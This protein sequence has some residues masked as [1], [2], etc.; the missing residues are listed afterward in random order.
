[1]AVNVYQQR[2]KD[3]M[4]KETVYVF[5]DDSLDEALALMVENRV[6]AL[7][8]VDGHQR[9]IG[10]IS[11]TDL[12]NLTREFGD[13][14]NALAHV[15]GLAHTLLTE[16]LS[17]SG[18]LNRRV[19]ELMTETVVSIGPDDTLIHAATEMVRSRVHRLAV[20]DR[21]RRLRGI[22]STMDILDAF[23]NSSEN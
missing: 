2:A 4:V 15:G 21:Q 5:A 11:A 1:M 22:L 17:T 6:S 13:E 20:V 18:L 23:A 7:P 19:Q 10:F 16:K 3:V 14:L 9:C 12:L 8:V